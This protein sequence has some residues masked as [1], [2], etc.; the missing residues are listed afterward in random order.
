MG[1]GKLKNKLIEGYRK[2]GK[3]DVK[4]LKEWEQAKEKQLGS[5]ALKLL[6]KANLTEKDWQEIRIR[7]K[8]ES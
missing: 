6:K 1:N 4:I 5:R 2:M 8:E 3:E 7:R